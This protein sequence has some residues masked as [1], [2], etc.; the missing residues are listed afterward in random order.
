MQGNPSVS[1]IDVASRPLSVHADNICFP[2][3]WVQSLLLTFTTAERKVQFECKIFFWTKYIISSIRHV[4]YGGI[5][6]SKA[7][8]CNCDHLQ[9]A[10]DEWI[11]C[12]FVVVSYIALTKRISYNFFFLNRAICLVLSN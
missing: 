4:C 5:L 10:K 9:P 7:H 1:M 8:H 6:A 2:Y 3:G 12:L 11:E